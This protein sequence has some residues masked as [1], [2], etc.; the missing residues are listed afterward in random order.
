MTKCVTDMGP[1]PSIMYTPI[2]DHGQSRFHSI[3]D[4]TL[5]RCAT[6]ISLQKKGSRVHSGWSTHQ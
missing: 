6:A 1:G 3:V 4:P 2:V 5:I